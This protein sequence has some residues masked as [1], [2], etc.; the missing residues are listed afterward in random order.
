LSRPLSPDTSVRHRVPVWGTRWRKA[1]QVSKPFFF[2]LPWLTGFLGFTLG[3]LVLT[4]YYSFTSYNLMTSPVWVGLDNYRTL[5]T[6]DPFFT[7]ALSNTFYM[8][9]VGV[10][11][12][13]ITSLALALLLERPL[14]GLGIYRAV[15]YLPVLVPPVASALLWLWVLNPEGGLLNSFLSLSGVTGPGWFT[16]PQ[17]SKPGILLI[18]VWTCGNTMVIFLAG[19]RQVPPQ[20]YEAAAI[21]SAGGW[22]RFLH[23]TLPQITPVLFF[24]VLISAIGMFGYF[25]QA[26]VI[27]GGITNSNGLGSPDGSLLFYP[28]YLFQT[29]FSYLHMGYASALALILFLIVVVLSGILFLT[30]REWVYYEGRIR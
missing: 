4:C 10:P 2:L 17:W 11:L 12:V 3:P 6:N 1:R 7:Q 19:L 30:S 29:A 21:D 18:E 15:F 28:L 25:T 13:T 26:Y 20:L 27:S 14:P 22:A 9:A 23:V 16:D 8:V 5:L 24:N